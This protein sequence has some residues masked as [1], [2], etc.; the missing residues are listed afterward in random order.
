MKNKKTST[1]L[2]FS[3]LLPS[4]NGEKVIGD[5]LKSILTQT[6]QNF[7]III[8]DDCSKDNTINVI[9]KF[10]DKRIKL[11]RNKKNLGYSLNLERCRQEAKGDILYLMGQDDVLSKNAFLNT[12]RAFELSPDIGAVIRPYYQF[13]NDINIPVR[14]TGPQLNSNKDEILNITDDYKK[15]VLV[16]HNAGQL[17]GLALR[18]KFVDIPF[19][20]DI[21]PCHVYPFMSVFKKHP[22][23]FL[24]DYTVAVRIVS[25]QARSVSSIYDKSP[26]KTWIEFYDKIFSEK[27][28]TGLKKYCINNYSAVYFVGLI[29]IK[30]YARKY[31]YLL[32]EIFYFLKYRWQN[33]FHP[34]FWFFSLLTLITP[35]SIL[36]PLNDWYKNNI[37][38]LFLKNIKFEYK[39]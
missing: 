31:R 35:K 21:F 34:L 18:R 24:K 30:N 27:K 19:H 17:S 4:Y 11:F 39:K 22:I 3:I 29:Q 23:V 9:E 28:Y 16:I 20:K 7:E 32:R 25:S 5:C 12:Y 10:N 1:D 36:I 6:Y 26:L 33:I 37:Y 8:S 2:K 38:S 15:I 14:N 13:F